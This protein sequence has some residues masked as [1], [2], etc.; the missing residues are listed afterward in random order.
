MDI[1]K[2]VE[3]VFAGGYDYL[4]VGPHETGQTVVRMDRRLKSSFLREEVLD[5]EFLERDDKK[6][7]DELERHLNAGKPPGP[8]RWEVRLSYSGARFN[9]VRCFGPQSDGMRLG[10]GPVHIPAGGCSISQD[11]RS[12]PTPCTPSDCGMCPSKKR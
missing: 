7:A 3:E 4:F 12:K 9:G 11:C 6:V 8:Q 5:E 10:N 2:I 1:P